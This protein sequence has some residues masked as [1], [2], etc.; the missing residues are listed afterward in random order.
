MEEIITDTC[1][2]ANV[3]VKLLKQKMCAKKKYTEISIRKYKI[4]QKFYISRTG[5][6]LCSD[7]LIR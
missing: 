2:A 1:L 6:P 3:N 7:I 5:V 4:S